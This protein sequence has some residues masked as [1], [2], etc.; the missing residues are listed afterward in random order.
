ML[1]ASVAFAGVFRCVDD[2]SDFDGVFVFI[3]DVDA[4]G[5][6]VFRTFVVAAKEGSIDVVVACRLWSTEESASAC[7]VELPDLLCTL[8][9]FDSDSDTFADFFDRFALDF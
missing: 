8:F 1:V 9:F 7:V 6:S 3:L 4:F 5:E 2:L